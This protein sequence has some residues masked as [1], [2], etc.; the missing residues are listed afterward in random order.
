LIEAG[1]DVNAKDDDGNTPLMIA[2]QHSSTPAIVTL[3]IEAGA[4]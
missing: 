4:V 2:A 3:L 1:A